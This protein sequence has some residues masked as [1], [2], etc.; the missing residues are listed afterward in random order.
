M[1]DNINTLDG[2]GELRLTLMAALAQDESRKISERVKWGQK[3]QME[4]GVVFGRSLLGYR[5]RKGKLYLV[6]EP[7]QEYNDNC[8]DNTSFHTI[9]TPSSDTN[10]PKNFPTC[11]FKGRKAH[12]NL[13]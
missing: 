1:I 12:R 3:K 11:H 8:C 13:L 5:V 2:D 10:C 9:T 7:N 4:K 6:E